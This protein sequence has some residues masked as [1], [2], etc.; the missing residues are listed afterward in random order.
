SRKRGAPF[1]INLV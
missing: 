1:S